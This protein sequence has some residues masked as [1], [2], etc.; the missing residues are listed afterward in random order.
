M[1]QETAQV[2]I[3]L[4]GQVLQIKQAL[5]QAPL[6]VQGTFHSLQ[7]IF[8][9]VAV[10]LS[11]VLRAD[12]APSSPT[13]FLPTSPPLGGSPDAL[14]SRHAPSLLLTAAGRRGPSASRPHPGG[15]SRRPWTS[16][17]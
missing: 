12:A 1:L 14:T 17:G 11:N 8:P 15:R 3:L 10:W 6:Q 7:A 4:G 2:D 16:T 9:E 13:P 5:V